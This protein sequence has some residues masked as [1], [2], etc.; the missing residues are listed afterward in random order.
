VSAYCTCS[1]PAFAPTAGAPNIPPVGAAAGVVD[2]KSP[3]PVDAGVP[4]ADAAGA[5]APKAEVGACTAEPKRPP[6]AGAGALPNADVAPNVDVVGAGAPNAE[7]GAGAPKAEVAGA[8]RVDPNPVEVL[9]PPNRPPEAVFVAG[10]FDP[11]SPP[12]GAA[13]VPK[14]VEVDGAPKAVGAGAGEPNAPKADGAGA[15]VAPNPPK[16]VE[17]AAAGVPKPNPPG[18]PVAGAPNAGAGVGEPKAGVAAGAPKRD[19]PPPD[20][21][22]KGDVAGCC[23]NIIASNN[24]VY[25]VC[26]WQCQLSDD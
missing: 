19:E 2:P 16:P 26:Q 20:G 1:V 5:G 9:P 17:G 14:G 8:A 15:G 24:Y 11:K 12:E 23:P 10:V 22:P 13:D 7:V 4:N 21:L 6:V 25:Y 3:P 18:V